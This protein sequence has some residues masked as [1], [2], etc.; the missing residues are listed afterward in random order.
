MVGRITSYNVCY[1]KLLRDALA[2]DR[3]ELKQH[4]QTLKDA[5]VRINGQLP[6]EMPVS[7]L[8]YAQ[9]TYSEYW[10][11]RQNFYV[12]TRYNRSPLYAMVVYNL[13][14]AIAKSN[15]AK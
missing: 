8:K 9:P 6:N 2:Q 11:A 14:Q 4:W 15:H 7:L 10:V 13:S 5:G 1:T 12:I 3:V